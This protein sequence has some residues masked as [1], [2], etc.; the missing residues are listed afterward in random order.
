MTTPLP[1][2]PS[3]RLLAA[4]LVVAGLGM[5]CNRDKVSQSVVAKDAAPAAA[6]TGLPE[7]H[8]PLQG[9]MGGGMGAGMSGMQGEVPPPPT[10]AQGLAWTLPQGWTEKRTGGMRVA[11]LV[12]GKEGI[13]DI[14]V[15]VLSGTAG[16]EL[17]NVNRW[18]GQIGLEPVE[19][20]AL[21]GMRTVVKAKIGPLHVYD[22]AGKGP[23]ML[24][25][26][27]TTPDGN[28]WFF[29]LVGDPGPVAGVRADFLK[30]MESVRLG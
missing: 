18:R 8:P 21:A 24:V 22:L 5:A 10:P 15:T 1:S 20:K 28:T 7:G 2:S 26:L 19:E 4:A 29:K 17:A 6:P 16:G 23:R 14:S 9:G 30:L 27:H 13:A 25:G 11:T 3:T 12:P